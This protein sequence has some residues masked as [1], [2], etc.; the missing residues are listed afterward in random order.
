MHFFGGGV[1]IDIYEGKM[2][3]MG[4][5]RLVNEKSKRTNKGFYCIIWAK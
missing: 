5:A 2:P 3:V 1:K 4:E